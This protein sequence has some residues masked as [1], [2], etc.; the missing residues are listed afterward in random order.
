MPPLAATYSCFGMDSSDIKKATFSNAFPNFVVA[1]SL[2]L[3]VVNLYTFNSSNVGVAQG[4]PSGINIW[5]IRGGSALTKPVSGSTSPPGS[6]LSISGSGLRN[7]PEREKGK[8]KR[9]RKKEEKEKKR[10]RKK[11]EEEKKER[12][13]KKEEEKKKRK[14]KKREEKKN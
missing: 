1:G 2:G 11:E 5:F 14:K 12:K 8:K 3:R 9:E 10:E 13:K 6:K 7:P 4:L